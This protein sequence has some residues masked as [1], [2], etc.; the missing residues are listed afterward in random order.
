MD[1]NYAYRMEESK[2]QTTQEDPVED[3]DFG[4]IKVRANPHDIIQPTKR[5][6]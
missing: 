4:P 2:N 1:I 5:F 3:E 6:A